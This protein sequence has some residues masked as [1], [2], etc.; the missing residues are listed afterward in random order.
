[1]EAPPFLKIFD[2]DEAGKNLELRA[3]FGSCRIRM[4]WYQFEVRPDAARIYEHSDDSQQGFQALGNYLFDFDN[5]Q[6]R[7]DEEYK[8]FVQLRYRFTWL[9]Q[10]REDASR[11]MENDETRRIKTEM[12][13]K[14]SALKKLDEVPAPTNTQRIQKEMLVEK[15]KQLQAQLD[16]LQ[17]TVVIDAFNQSVENLCYCRHMWRRIFQRQ[18]A[19]KTLSGQ[20]D[21]LT[22]VWSEQ[23]AL[24]F[25]LQ[26]DLPAL[27]K[28]LMRVPVITN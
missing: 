6:K 28:S 26:N 5:V 17:P 11:R 25:Q 12:V 18:L 1:M 13:E 16:A 2:I 15:I 27:E 22:S 9:R 23:R 10:A 3:K 19:N 20:D 4:K 21:G 7:R 24:V 14:T 8:E